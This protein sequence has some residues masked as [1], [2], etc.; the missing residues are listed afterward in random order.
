MLPQIFPLS[1][2]RFVMLLL[3]IEPD[4]VL[5]IHSSSALVVAAASFPAMVGSTTTTDL[6]AA[7]CL[8]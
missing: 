2:V 3:E 4:I 1:Q 5:H 7:A 8:V 6:S